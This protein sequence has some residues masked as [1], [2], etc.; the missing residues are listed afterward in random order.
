MVD[1]SPNKSKP[2]PKPSPSAVEHD[3]LLSALGAEIRATR[4]ESG[5]TLK[6]LAT[7]SGL[8]VRFLSD[9][10]TGKANVSVLRLAEVARTI[11]APPSAL[12]AR[13]ENRASAADGRASAGGGGAVVA[14]LGLRG[15]G[16]S[17]IGARAAQGLGIPFV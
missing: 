5:M 7:Q 9:L 10:E 12:L 1:A 11:G 3:R 14:L 2:R 16:K 15:A 4:N 6:Q 8:S 13:A 17:T